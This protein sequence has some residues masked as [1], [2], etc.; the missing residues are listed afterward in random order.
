MPGGL[1]PDEAANGLD[2][3][4]MQKGELQPFYERG[5]G[6]EALFFY[7]IWGSIEVFGKGHWQ[8][9]IVSALIGLLSVVFCFFVTKRLFSFN[10]E[11]NDEEGKSKAIRIALLASFLMAVSTWHIVLSRTA[12]RAV[13]IPLFASLVFYFLIR[14]YQAKTR[15]EMLWSAFFAGG[16]FAGGFYTYIAFRIMAP[17]LF[18]LLLWPLLGSIRTGSFKEQVKKYFLPAVYFVVAFVIVFFPLGKYFYDHPGSF[19]GRAGQVSVFNPSLYTVDGVQ[20][21]GKPPLSA[22][23]PAMLEVAR[24]QI[25]GFFASGDLNWRSNISGVSFLSELYSPFFGVGLV[26]VSFFMLWYFFAPNK[27]FY[28]WKYFLLGSWFWLMLMPVVTTAE[29]IPHGLRSIGVIP[30][31]FIIS[32]WALYEFCTFFWRLHKKVWQ[33]YCFNHKDPKWVEDS[34]FVPLKMRFVNFGLKFVVVVFCFALVFQAY[35]LYFVYAYNDPVNFYYFRSDL[36]QVSKYLVER[37]DKQHTYLIL[38]KFSVQTTDYLTSDPKGNFNSKCSVP[39]KQ[40]DPENSWELKNLTT[41]D[42]IVFTQ[43]T[44]FDIKKFQEY[45]PDARL[46]MELRN[47]FGQTILA[48]YKIESGQTSESELKD[49]KTYKNEQYGFEF[50]Y[51]NG[52]ESSNQDINYTDWF[53]SPTNGDVLGLKLLRKVGSASEVANVEIKENDCLGN[54]RTT[55]DHLIYSTNTDALYVLY[56]SAK[57]ESYIYII[58]LSSGLFLRMS[59]H[60]DFLDDWTEEKKLLTFKQIIESFKSIK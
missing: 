49:W 17:L 9:H 5:N 54:E 12:F 3:N 33:K 50:K 29:G 46:K 37:C 10:V 23:L 60:D 51:P 42:E 25:K 21:T 32:A 6:R 31:V 11:E 55:G 58:K 14:T 47:K 34:H 35:F 4:S 15:K 28:Y 22:V 26:L 40:V 52:W 2:I 18:G 39:Y 45:H 41:E 19:V 38:D 44:I 24:V 27:R 56:C 1:F 30:P 20:L 48:V 13:Q 36:T 7:M 59:Y 16:F 53:I 57:S 8:H 43:S